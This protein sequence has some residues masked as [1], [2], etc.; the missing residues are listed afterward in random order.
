MKAKIRLCYKLPALILLF[1]AGLII[2]AGIFPAVGFACS[3][4]NAR[5]L[6]DAIKRRWLQCF[7]VLICLRVDR[8]GNPSGQRAML[9]ANHVSWLDII[10]IGQYLPAYFVAKS[11]IDHWPVIGFLSRQAGTVFIR[12]GDKKNIAA[13][14]DKIACLFEQNSTV[15]AFPEGTTTAGNEVLN[16]HASLFQPALSTKSA[17][18]PV[19]IQYQ[20]TARDLAPFIGDETFIGHLLKMLMLDEIEATLCFLPCIATE[21]KTRHRISQEARERIARHLSIEP[22]SGGPDAELEPIALPMGPV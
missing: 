12:R 15:I 1:G 5:N 10:V 2:A 14:S 21:G 4:S 8:K 13:T 18:Q 19:S 9:A 17:V 3:A 20:G 11:D 16:F 6:R 7:A 22:P